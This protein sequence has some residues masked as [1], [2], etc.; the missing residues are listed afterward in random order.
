MRSYGL[1]VLKRF[2]Q[3]ALVVLIGISLTFFVAHLTPV[4][5]VEHMVSQMTAFGDTSPEAVLMMREALAELYGTDELLLAQ[6]V[7]YWGRML[8]LDFGP[9]LSAFPTPVSVLIGRALPW[10]VGLLVICTLI[11]W[12]LGNLLGGLAGYYR[13][14]RILRLFGLIVM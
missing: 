2:G 5:P 3:F 1:Y 7:A 9:S 8:M 4:D 12:T 14:S 6:Y 11:V 13:D 10:T